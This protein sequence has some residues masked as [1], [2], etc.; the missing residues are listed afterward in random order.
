MK[1][2]IEN[3]TPEAGKLLIKPLRVRT[4]TVETQE[5]YED[6]E[7]KK[8]ENETRDPLKQ[9]EDLPIM[10]NRTVKSKAPYEMQLAEVIASGDP[11]KPIGS[12]IV[13]SIKFVREFDLFKNT[14]LISNYDSQGEYNID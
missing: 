12:T 11:N 8:K 9:P 4:R 14:F 2:S 10:K 6:E 3:Y 7:A 5:A 1:Y 13:Y